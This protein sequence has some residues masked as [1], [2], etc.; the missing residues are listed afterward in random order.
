MI[1][2]IREDYDTEPK[3]MD[4]VYE[5]DYKIIPDFDIDKLD[6]YEKELDKEDEEILA[7]PEDTTYRGFYIDNHDNSYF[8]IEIDRED[9]DS[10]EV[11]FRTLDEA[12]EFI[13]D[14]FKFINNW[15]SASKKE[16][17]DVKKIKNESADLKSEADKEQEE[18]NESADL[19]IK[20]DYTE[21][22]IYWV[23]LSDYPQDYVSFMVKDKEEA[24]KAAEKY[25]KD[26][27]LDNVEI[28]NI[29]DSLDNLPT[30]DAEEKETLQEDL[31]W[32]LQNG[33]IKE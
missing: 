28:L 25:I 13:D 16:S 22:Q 30:Y 15:S 4:D 14:L 24:K 21:E 1:K 11:Q 12:K 17:I 5:D 27:H 6:E 20:N 29:F 2:L 3:L 32:A 26:N 18:N 31:D 9:S 33:L 19:S 23:S 10:I 8:T 7:M